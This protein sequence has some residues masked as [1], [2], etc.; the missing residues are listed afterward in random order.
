MICVTPHPIN[1]AD[2][3]ARVTHD[4]SI[5]AAVTFCGFVRGDAKEGEAPLTTLT[6]EHWPGATERA[7][8]DIRQKAMDR[9]PLKEA[10]VVHRY[11]EMQ[12]GDLIVLTATWSPHRE[13]AFDGARFIMDYL[14]TD[15]PFWKQV[16]RA[17]GS[18]QWVDAAQKDDTARANWEG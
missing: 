9:F 3:L 16:T 14:K 11:G 8:Q 12:V 2:E 17:D 13:A 4:G 18:T 1:V 7:L 6:L 15:A 10:L 5:G